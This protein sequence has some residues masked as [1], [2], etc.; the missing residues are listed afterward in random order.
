MQAFALNRVTKDTS[1]WGNFSDE[2][3]LVRTMNDY[4]KCYGIYSITMLC[5]DKGEVVA[6]NTLA[7]DGSLLNTTPLQGRSYADASWFKDAMNGRFYAAAGSSLSGTVI[8]DVHF[9]QDVQSICSTEGLA[10]TFSAPVHDD[11]GKVIGVWRNV[12]DFKFIEEILADQFEHAVES[13]LTSADILIVD[14]QG[15]VWAEASG[16]TVHNG[17]IERDIS[18][19]GKLNLAKEGYAPVV[20]ALTNEEGFDLK[21][22]NPKSQEAQTVAWCGRHG[23]LGFPGMEWGFLARVKTSE[24]LALHDEML[25]TVLGGLAATTVLLTFVSGLIVRHLLKPI[26][27]AVKRLDEIAEGEGELTAKMNETSRDEMGDLARSFNKF[28]EKMRVVIAEVLTSASDVAAAS[29]EIAAT[30]ETLSK[31]VSEQQGRAELRRC[32]AVHA[33]RPRSCQ[34]QQRGD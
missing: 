2:N 3:P 26:R 28:C 25:L 1:N 18:V 15:V 4:V 22:L 20:K 8:E 21:E 29:T 27:T 12:A 16:Q 19:L 13:G 5:N 10:M 14:K 17:N 7:P 11:D 9:N 34:S 32:R 6:L 33:E 23:A 24:A 31:G 30:A